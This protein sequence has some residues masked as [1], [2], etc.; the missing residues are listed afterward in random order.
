MISQKDVAVGF[1]A[2][3]DGP[4]HV[5]DS[6][7]SELVVYAKLDCLVFLGVVLAEPEC[8]VKVFEPFQRYVVPCK[9]GR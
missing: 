5:I 7:L 8:G 9:I 2:S 1:L 6:R 3:R 4:D